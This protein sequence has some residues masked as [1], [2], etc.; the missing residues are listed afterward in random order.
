MHGKQISG[1]SRSRTRDTSRNKS[2]SRSSWQG[3]ERGRRVQ[4]VRWT[5]II[6]IIISTGALVGHGIGPEE[7]YKAAVGFF[8]LKAAS[9]ETRESI[10]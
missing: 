2:R 6:I 5:L 7:L 3:H 4:T 10:I 8:R 9:Q 1:R